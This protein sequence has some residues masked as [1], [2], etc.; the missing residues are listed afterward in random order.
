M[1]REIKFRG[2]SLVTNEWVYGSLVKVGNESHIVGLDEVDRFR[3]S[4]FS[5]FCS[6]RSILTT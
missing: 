2:K 4:S 1:N 3:W 6:Y 5:L